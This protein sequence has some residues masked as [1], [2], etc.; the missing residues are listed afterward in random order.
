MTELSLLVLLRLVT[1]NC[2]LLTLAVL[3]DRG[4]D[5][6]TLNIRSA[7]LERTVLGRSKHLVEGIG[8][9]LGYVEL[10]NEDNVALGNF[11]LLSACFGITANTKST[12]LSDGVCPQNSLCR[13]C[14]YRA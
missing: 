3:Y 14:A 6:R 4:S 11:V 13:R 12:S 2:D 9:A 7:A 8:F 5:R 10:L 1:Q